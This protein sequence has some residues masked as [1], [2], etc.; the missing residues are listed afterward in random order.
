MIRQ[1]QERRLKPLLHHCKHHQLHTFRSSASIPEQ[2]SLKMYIIMLSTRKS[3]ELTV[4]FAIQGQ[5][6]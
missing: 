1:A 4:K 2:H 3:D 6:V 5:G